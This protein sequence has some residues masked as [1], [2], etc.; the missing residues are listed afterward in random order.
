[1]NGEVFVLIGAA[2]SVAFFHTIAGPDH[3]LPFVA[4]ARAGSWGRAKTIWITALCGLGHVGSSLLLAALGVLL[5]RGADHFFGF[6][7]LRGDLA[8]WGLIIFGLLYAMWGLRRARGG[9]THSHHHV[10]A[11]GTGHEHVHAHA[12]AHVHKHGG[13][14]VGPWALFIVFVLGPCEPLIPMIVY[15]SAEAGAG[16][17]FA[18]AAAFTLVTVVTMLGVVLLAL[19]GMQRLKMPRV[20]RYQHVFAGLVILFCGVGIRFLGL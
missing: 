18:V 5:F 14:G 8:A 1:V 19:G 4:M 12:E 16:A 2:I 17:A 7:G 6:E 3:Y 10:H 9:H 15:A 11:D 13:P 20:E